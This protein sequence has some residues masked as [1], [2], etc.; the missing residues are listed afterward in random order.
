MEKFN[1]YVEY[2]D[3]YSEARFPGSAP[4]SFLGGLYDKGKEFINTLKG[5]DSPDVMK[6][7]E[8]EIYEE[9]AREVGLNLTAPDV[10]YPSSRNKASPLQRA[11]SAMAYSVVTSRSNGYSVPK[12]YFTILLNELKKKGIAN[13]SDEA[14]LAKFI[15]SVVTG[16]KSLGFRPILNLEPN[17]HDEVMQHSKFQ[18]EDREAARKAARQGVRGAAREMRLAANP[19]DKKPYLDALNQALSFARHATPPDPKV[20]EMIQSLIDAFS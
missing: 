14:E 7:Q 16:I 12:Q 2:R 10:I 19:T 18:S 4:R 13:F 11:L 5:H 6:N 15:G 8:K 1:N 17:F 20:I 3:R 9:I